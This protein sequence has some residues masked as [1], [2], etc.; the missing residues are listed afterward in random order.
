MNLETRILEHVNRFNDLRR[1]GAAITP[2]EVCRDCPELLDAVK[3]RLQGGD[4]GATAGWLE[5]VDTGETAA[6]S[7]TAS[8]PQHL[9][10]RVGRYVIGAEIARGGM[11]MVVRVQDEAFDRPLAMK[12][13]LSVGGEDRFLREARLT[14]RLQHPGIAPVQEMGRLED[15][16]PYFIMKLVQGDSL[17]VMLQRRDSVNQDLPRWLAMF[18]QMCQ[19]LAYAHAQGIIHRDLKPA[20]IMVGAFGEVQ[21]MDWGLAKILKS[22]DGDPPVSAQVPADEGISRSTWRDE[23]TIGGAV[24]GTPAFMAP[25]QARGEIDNLD[26]RCDVFGLGGILAVIL[27]GKPPFVSKDS[28][29]TH[30]LAMQGDLSEA[31]ARLEICGAD[32]DLVRLAKQCLAPDKQNRP[33]DARAVADAVAGYQA[34]LQQRLKQAEIDRAAALVKAEEETKRRQVEHAKAD[35]ERKRRRALLALAAAVGILILGATGAFAWYQTDQARQ[36]SELT[37]RAQYLNKE[38]AAA[39]DDGEKRR[40]N[41][42]ARLANQKSVNE[43][44]SDIDHWPNQLKEIQAAFQRARALADGAPILLDESLAARLHTL[45]ENVREDERNWDF[46]HAC[47]EAR[48]AAATMLAESIE[49]GAAA[50]LYPDIFAKAGLDIERGD[51]DTLVDKINQSSI[52]L[53]YLG[54]LD[55]WAHVIDAKDQRL[56][57]RLFSVA[58]R[59]DA[60]PWRQAFRQLPVWNSPQ[61]VQELAD[62]VQLKNQSLNTLLSVVQRLPEKGQVPFLRKTLVAHPRDFWLFAYLG[63]LVKDPLEREGCYRAALAIRPTSYFAHNNLALALQDKK[64]LPEAALHL[65]QALDI[66]PNFVPGHNNLGRVLADQRD[67]KGAI[68]HYH[69]ALEISPAHYAARHNLALALM[70]QND[71]DGALL[72]LRL[73]LKNDANSALTHNLLGS[74]SRTKKNYADAI[75]HF[76]KA[77]ELNPKSVEVHLNLG[78]TFADTKQWDKAIPHYRAALAISPNLFQAHYNLAMALAIRNDLDGAISHFRKAVAS[79]PDSASAHFNLGIA[80]NIVRDREGAIDNYRKALGLDPNNLGAHINLGTILAAKKDLKTAAQHFQAAVTLNP[81]FPK[82]LG[83][84]GQVLL[85]QGQFAEARTTTL[86]C[87]NMLPADHPL[88][89]QVQH[90]L[91]RCDHFLNLEKRLSAILA[92]QE[93]PRQVPELFDLADYSLEFKHYYAAAARFFAEVLAKEPKVGNDL[94]NKIRYTA[95]AAALLAAAGKGGDAAS[96]PP[97]DKAKLRQQALDWL[98]ADLALWQK[99]LQVG[100]VQDVLALT[101]RLTHWQKDPDLAS[102][103]HPSARG[104]LPTE[105]QKKWRMLWSDVDELQR[106]AAGCFTSSLLH[107]SLTATE[108]AKTHELEV[109]AGK[110]LVVDLHSPAFD[111]FLR[112]EDQAGKTL[113]ENDDV[114]PGQTDARIVYAPAADSSLRIVA[115]SFQQRGQGAYTLVFRVFQGKK[116]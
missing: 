82:A 92:G 36:E 48:L 86:T 42:H 116:N 73:A 43:L 109:L 58:N 20:N 100:K 45:E 96:I 90:Q 14:G 7:Q 31:F 33:V 44:L 49:R 103:R 41:L 25:E 66:N 13:M 55:H 22:S 71:A 68:R 21:V 34:A 16:R 69:K 9:P 35:A 94:V 54:A 1:Q 2:E 60:D 93:P 112:L 105:E 61:R 97:D 79:N 18:A 99:N 4:A 11:G 98:R 115:T 3:S 65:H 8:R 51:I 15:G 80:L 46:G 57:T 29:H 75:T 23:A 83:A 104:K 78:L 106:E 59:L 63:Y 53:I 47:D 39:L 114:R 101:E 102:V 19:T 111:A 32:V 12:L 113:A 37:V 24:M 87:L 88:R 17:D 84:L 89:K 77:L 70:Q 28:V 5:N 26:Q 40:R 95:A 30:R 52:R 27:T 10:E 91:G 72:H 38:V 85:D 64:E 62:K 108:S 50:T 74:A 110:T 67:F 76:Q 81:K 107:G 6:W 56:L